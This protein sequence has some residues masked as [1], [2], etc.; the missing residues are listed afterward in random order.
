[1]LLKDAIAGATSLVG[2]A[3]KRIV[4]VF[5]SF[6][7]EDDDNENLKDSFTKHFPVDP[8]ANEGT[9]LIDGLGLVAC[10]HVLVLATCT[11]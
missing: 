6:R 4:Q 2:G 9:T 1:M 3:R 7:T 10:T 5:F 8:S 11:I